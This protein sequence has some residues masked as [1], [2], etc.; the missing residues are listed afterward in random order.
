MPAAQDNEALN[1]WGDDRTNC[2]KH[3][4]CSASARS[5]TRNLLIRRQRFKI[6]QY[7]TS[8]FS[9]FCLE[10]LQKNSIYSTIY[11]YSILVAVRLLYNPLGMFDGCDNGYCFRWADRIWD[12]EGGRVL[13]LF[14]SLAQ[15]RNH[16]ILISSTPLISPFICA[17]FIGRFWG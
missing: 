10:N 15:Q 3:L 8:R 11:T 4:I 6:T 12:V 2:S 17:L 14:H 1:C 7:K 13:L 16:L 5:R 9:L